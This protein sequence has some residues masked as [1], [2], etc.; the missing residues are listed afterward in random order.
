MARVRHFL[1]SL[2]AAGV[3]SCAVRRFS[4][5][6]RAERPLGGPSLPRFGLKCPPSALPLSWRLPGNLPIS[7]PCLEPG[8]YRSPVCQNKIPADRCRW[9]RSGTTAA[10]ATG[11]RGLA[12]RH[13]ITS[14]SNCLIFVFRLSSAVFVFTYP[15]AYLPLLSVVCLSYRLAVVHLF[16]VYQ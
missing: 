5:G 16:A 1:P 4:L 2:W 12:S 11:L 3:N 10:V 6:L 13:C 14:A 9:L 8:R 7:G 15:Q